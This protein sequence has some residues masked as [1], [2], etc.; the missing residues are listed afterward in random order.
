MIEYVVKPCRTGAA[1]EII[2]KEEGFKKIMEKIEEMKEFLLVKNDFI[3]ILE[4]EN[5][6]ISISDRRKIIFRGEEREDVV[7]KLFYKI[8][9]SEMPD[10][11]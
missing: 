5:L 1:Y 3:T 2:I 10:N 8:F 4:I 6:H 7:K 9:L 11:K